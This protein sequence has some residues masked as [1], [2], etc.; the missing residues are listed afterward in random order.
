MNVIAHVIVGFNHGGTELQCQRLITNWPDNSRH[1]VIAL[2][3]SGGPMRDVFTNINNIDVVESLSQESGRLQLFIQLRTFFIRHHVTHIINHYFGITHIVSALAGRSCGVRHNLALSG[4][5]ASGSFNFRL[6]CWLILLASYYLNVSIIACS[7]YVLESLR[8]ISLRLLKR[9]RYIYNGIEIPDLLD[10]SNEPARQI[11]ISM[12][13]R[14]DAIKDHETLIKAFKL[15]KSPNARLN[16]I[17]DGPLRSAIEKVITSESLIGRVHMM[18][19]RSDIPQLLRKS[20]LFVFSTT[21]MEGF[22]IAI[23]EA[24]ASTL[25]VI[26]SNVAASREVLGD[27]SLGLVP[28]GNHVALAAVMNDFIGNPKRR[29]ALGTENWLRAKEIFSID[30]SAK[31]FL[32]ALY[33]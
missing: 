13:A 20:D 7:I 31:N 12:V 19:S 22:G 33:D 18:G 6:K 28:P 16:I 15:V 1:V 9:A 2:D 27:K 29:F 30:F 17:G 24:M 26:A 4:N 25:P 10:R 5:P 3:G 11:V 23:I 14:L 32:E 8:S 21:E